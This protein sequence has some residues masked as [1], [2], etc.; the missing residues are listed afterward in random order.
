MRG[1]SMM[2]PVVRMLTGIPVL[3]M[4]IWFMMVELV[5]FFSL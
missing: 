1:R 4:K 2:V 5:L 3:V